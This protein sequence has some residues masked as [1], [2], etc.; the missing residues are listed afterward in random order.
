MCF[1]G[2]Q[3]NIVL[4]KSTINVIYI[5]LLFQLDFSM[6]HKELYHLHNVNITC[7]CGRSFMKIR[8]SNCPR[9]DSCGT[10]VIIFGEDNCNFTSLKKQTFFLDKI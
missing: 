2:I 5:K 9:I 10:P 1:Y 6:T 8:K 7:F 4:N 3:S